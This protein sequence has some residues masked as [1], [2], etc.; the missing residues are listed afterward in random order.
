MA[1]LKT[2]I[3]KRFFSEAGPE[4][5][6]NV[7]TEVVAHHSYERSHTEINDLNMD[8]IEID[9]VRLKTREGKTMTMQQFRATMPLLTTVLTPTVTIRQNAA[10]TMSSNQQ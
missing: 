5:I 2:F 7:D 4:N 3:L 6:A 8:G 9:A 10:F 1:L